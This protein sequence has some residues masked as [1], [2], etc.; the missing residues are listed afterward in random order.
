MKVLQINT[1]CGSGSTGRIA[2]DL[3]DVLHS[4]GHECCIA[5]GRGYSP[6]G[7]Q[8]IKIGNRLDFL[9]HVIITRLFDKHGFGSKKATKKLIK[10][11]KEFNP[12]VI[13][14]HNVHGYY[15]NIE[16]LFNYLSKLS[17]PVVWLL[18]DQWAIS[19]HSAYFEIEKQ[20]NLSLKI[21]IKSQKKKYPK[22]SFLSN[23]RENLKKKE[24]LFTGL[25][26][27]TVITPSNWLKNIID[28][29]FLSKYEV[30]VIHNGI[31]LNV[32]KYI[33]NDFRIENN[34]E[35]RIILLGVASVW[36]DR[37]GLIYFNNL[38]E[39]LNDNYKIVLVGVNRKQKSKLHGNIL[40]IE[41]TESVN[42]LADIYST[43]DI[44]LNPT[45]EDN[46][47]TTNV[48]AIACGTPVITF[49]TGG[50]PEALDD[51]TGAIVRNNS[52][53]E[54]IDKI[55]SFE[56]S[57]ELKSNCINRAKLFDKKDVYNRYVNLYIAKIKNRV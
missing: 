16:V 52:L 43:S 54:L 47:P 20:E 24:K 11:I 32:F 51:K 44:F 34:L 3:Y 12:D 46:F 6:K 8:T 55:T 25:N 31:D 28:S 7:Y 45:L 14:L 1:F 50:S 27:L 49:D 29:S 38:S 57:D 10:R 4:Q 21:F 19:G 41:R 53:D 35:D 40:S 33:P 5:Y 17:I 18:H 22:T 26:N 13:H 37:K 48:E 56:F 36:E 23:Y 39:R 2:T 30:K 42:K 9:S 15:L